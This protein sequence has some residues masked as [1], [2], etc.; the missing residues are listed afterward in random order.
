MNRT[1]RSTVPLL[2]AACFCAVGVLFVQVRPAEAL[3]TAPVSVTFGIT[4]GVAD[5]PAYHATLVPDATCASPTTWTVSS[6]ATWLKFTPSSGTYPGSTQFDI[7]ARNILPVGAYTAKIDVRCDGTTTAATITANLTVFAA[8]V[9]SVSRL[10]LNFKA[11]MNGT[12]PDE[13]FQVQSGGPGGWSATTS[14][15]W[16]TVTP[17][18]GNA[19][20]YNTPSGTVTAR[21]NSA[22]LTIGE[23]RGSITVT[24]AGAT[25]STLTIEVV[26]I[27][28]APPVLSATPRP[29]AIT[30][31]QGME[32]QK[33]MQVT[34]SGG[35][36]TDLNWS[37]AQPTQDWIKLSVTSSCAGPFADPIGG[38]LIGGRSTAISVCID[39]VP[40]V[41]S[42]LGIG[43]YTTTLT[44]NAPGSI[45]LSPGANVITINLR[46]QADTTPPTV[47]ADP[48]MVINATA[49]C[50]SPDAYR[51]D[52]TWT[53]SENGD[54]RIQWGE[55]LSG[56]GIPLYEKGSLVRTE[57]LD[58]VMHD[59][60]IITHTV[61]LDNMNYIFGGHKYYFRIGSIDRYSNP[62]PFVWTDKDPS[63][64]ALYLSFTVPGRCDDRP[65]TNVS[66]LL[67]TDPPPFFGSVTLT[68][69]AE[70]ES[71]VS[72][73]ELYE[74]TG[75]GV[76][77]LTTYLVPSGNCT[78]IGV[79]YTCQLI[80][81]FNTKTLADGPHNL[82]ARAYDT[83][84]NYADSPLIT[85]D[86]SNAVP[87]VSNLKENVVNAAGVWS[88]EITWDTNIP[89]D[90]NVQY[91][92][93]DDDGQFRGYSS[94]ASGDDTGR[95]NLTSGF[96]QH[97]VTL[98]NLSGGRV[99]H[100]MVT[101]CPT[102]I[103]DPDRCGH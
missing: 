101:S 70:D 56:S 53:T 41:A 38:I 59:G 97:T 35:S 81:A 57:G 91:G 67:P 54:T 30:I 99:Y 43:D 62:S 90:S 47:L 95:D 66:L 78:S 80:K 11:P 1:R 19:A 6:A 52:I 103:T 18:S 31:D 15:P 27:I 77:V 93:E 40:S 9:L 79:T 36:E 26:F 23:R 64:P 24:S 88:A 50:S 22:T 55:D 87:T 98:N 51:A 71:L 34:N 96:D 72:Q 28:T 39:S 12:A 89:S 13:K 20:S 7:V 32:V 82:F 61:T 8:P 102:G 92:I 73:F 83:I 69:S 85:L 16:L 74:Q 10:N 65:P 75:T 49:T 76:N 4:A 63:K 58:T 17:N 37:I 14:E 21:V 84:G 44:V 5:S 25:P 100:Y 46:V 94:V 29:L 86:V 2:V 68:M 60:G 33:I 45:L 3:W 42:A 48:P